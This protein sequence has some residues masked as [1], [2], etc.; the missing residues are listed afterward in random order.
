M[1]AFPTTSG[2]PVIVAAGFLVVF[3]L[4]AVGVGRFADVG[5]LRTPDAGAVQ[6]L[7]LRFEDAEDGSVLVASADARPIERLLPGTNGFVRGVM[8]GLARERRIRGI[9]D[10]TPF[11]LSRF[12]NGRLLLEDPETRH[13]VELQAFGTTNEQVFARLLDEEGTPR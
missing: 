4:L 1:P 7:D 13:I 11:R 12:A 2:S 8:R 5:T 9:G 3:S 10:A 6:T